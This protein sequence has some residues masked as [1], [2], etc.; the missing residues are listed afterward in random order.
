MS[1]EGIFELQEDVL[2]LLAAGSHKGLDA[3][4]SSRPAESTETAGHFELSFGRS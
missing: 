4:I 2:L 1:V 3:G